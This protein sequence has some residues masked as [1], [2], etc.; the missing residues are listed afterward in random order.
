MSTVRPRMVWSADLRLYEDEI[1]SVEEPDMRRGG[2]RRN[3]PC[4]PLLLVANRLPCYSIDLGA[5]HCPINLDRGADSRNVTRREVEDDLAVIRT[6]GFPPMVRASSRV[7]WETIDLDAQTLM[8]YTSGREKGLKN[9]ALYGPVWFTATRV[10]GENA[11]N[12]YAGGG[13]RTHTGQSPRDFKSKNALPT[14][15]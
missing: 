10:N 9:R 7:R 15:P 6:N 1:R 11:E 3:R 4:S 5:T 13:N 12:P 8:I 14:F 2:S